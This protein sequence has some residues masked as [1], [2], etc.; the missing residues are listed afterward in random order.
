MGLGVWGIPSG[1]SSCVYHIWGA[2]ASFIGDTNV[3]AV[4]KDSTVIINSS[5]GETETLEIFAKQAKEADAELLLITQN[6]DSTIGLLSNFI[7]KIPLIDSKQVMKTFPEQYSFLLLDYITT[8]IIPKL[9]I[10]N[11]Y[12]KKK[13]SVFE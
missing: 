8:L 4:D 10:D 13:H 12:L 6:P 3:P 5:S 2:N 7:L 9:N 1:V 11:E